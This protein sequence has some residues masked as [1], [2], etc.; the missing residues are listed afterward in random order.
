MRLFVLIVV[1]SVS[2]ITSLIAYTINVIEMDKYIKRI[3]YNTAENFA[4]LVDVE[5]LTELR[6][7]AESKEYQKIR[8]NAEVKKNDTGIEEYLKEN[9]LW[10]KYSE[11]RAAMCS[12]LENMDDIKYLYII[13]LGDK[14]AKQDMF[15]L[16]DYDNPLYQTGNYDE[17]EEEL[18]GVDTSEYIEPVINNSSTWGNLCS[19]YAPVYDKNGNIV[20]HIGCDFDMEP[21]MNQRII[22][23]VYYL[24]AALVVTGIALLICIFLVNRILVK[25]LR[26]IIE[27]SKK[28]K[29]D[30]DKEMDY[31]QAG[32][33]TLSL[34]NND[35]ISDIYDSIRNTQMIVID[36]INDMLKLEKERQKYIEK[37]KKIESDFKEKKDLLEKVSD[38]AYHDELTQVGNK[39][40]Y[41]KMA[42]NLTKKIE[43]GAGKFAIA[44]IDLNNLKFINDYCGHKSGDIYIK[45]SCEIITRIFAHSNVYRVG[46][47]EFVVVLTGADYQNRNLL[48]KE[49]KDEFTKNYFNNNIPPYERFCASVGIAV[50]EQGDTV[51]SVFKRADQAMYSDKMF[52]KMKNGSYR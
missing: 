35:E 47:D 14:N 49:A 46:G 18:K 17:R 25:P 26:L 13:V 27:E 3:T 28:F 6:A 48:A 10:E 33:L 31:T 43:A 51:E 37:L 36:H 2:I 22:Q 15:L 11:Q 30:K 32:V 44:M 16:D 52:F 20:C 45:G 5:F 41:V 1:F 4:S 24:I 21:T 38:D 50:Y 29:P 39:A 19:A 8:T 12:Y 42:D 7:A 40:A 34:R 9:D 23:L